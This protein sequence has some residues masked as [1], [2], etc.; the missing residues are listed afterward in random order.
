MASAR[1]VNAHLEATSLDRWLIGLPLHH[2]G[3]FSILARCHENGAGFALWQEKWDAQKFAAACAAQGITFTSLVPAQ[4]FDLVHAKLVA[5]PS[6]RAVVVGG[7]SLDGELGARSRALGWPVLQSYGM[8]EAA[9]Q[10]A[11]EPLEDLHGDFEAGRLQVLPGWD[12]RCDADGRLVVRGGALASG[13]ALRNGDEW[14]WEPV[15][16]KT[17]LVTRDRVQVWQEGARRFLRFLG[18][19]SDFVKILGEMVCVSRLQ[20]RLERQMESSGLSPASAIIWPVTDARRGV[21]L[22]LVGEL[23]IAQLEAVCQLYNSSAPSFERLHPGRSLPSLP[24]TS[25]GKLDRAVLAS[26]LSES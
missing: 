6:L 17:G 26:I 18:R 11:T 21:R 23:T 9:S 5:P 25:L 15:D 7:G 20:A 3:G 2:V 1:A 12:L 10:I 16:S 8:T 19:D 13:Y 24:R 4:V 14:R 22:L